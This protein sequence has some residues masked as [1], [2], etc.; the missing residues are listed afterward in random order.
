MAVTQTVADRSGWGTTTM[1]DSDGYFYI[2]ISGHRRWY[3]GSGSPN[4]IITAPLGSIYNDRAASGL[5]WRNSDGSTT[6]QEI[7]DVT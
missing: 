3:N 2:E 4:G 1:E 5:M 6:W 7:G